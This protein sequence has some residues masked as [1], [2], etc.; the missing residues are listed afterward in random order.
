MK[1][2]CD[3][4]DSTITNKN[5]Q[6]CNMECMTS[7]MRLKDCMVCHE[8]YEPNDEVFCGYDYFCSKKCY[9]IHN[10]NHRIHNIE[11]ALGY[12][13]HGPHF[14]YE[15]VEITYKVRNVE[16]GKLIEGR[17][18][19]KKEELDSYHKRNKDKLT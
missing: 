10:I 8:K 12:G 15:L 7:F 11:C 16:T 6:F 18:G 5:K 3:Y 9:D 2:A 17:I 1:I 13:M 14:G 4:C 19:S